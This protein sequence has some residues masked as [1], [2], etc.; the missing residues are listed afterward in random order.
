MDPRE[1]SKKSF[2]RT[3]NCNKQRNLSWFKT[4]NSELSILSK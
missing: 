1:K 2:I 3:N 4:N